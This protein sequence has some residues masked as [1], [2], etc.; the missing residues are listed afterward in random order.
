[1]WD[2]KIWIN[3][4]YFNDTFV[5]MYSG[6]SRALY[7]FTN[8]ECRTLSW[9]RF[10]QFSPCHT[11]VPHD[12][13]ARGEVAHLFV[14]VQQEQLPLIASGPHRQGPVQT[15]HSL[16]ADLQDQGGVFPP[17][18]QRHASQ[19]HVRGALHQVFTMRERE[20]SYVWHM[21]AVG[22]VRAY[23]HTAGM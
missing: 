20:S 21:C 5:I 22:M 13:W 18:H 7:Y 9:W 11:F 17:L 14:W 15:C 6:Q 4:R 10:Q 23:R 12:K 2:H 8:T 3:W 19:P 16:T 1:M